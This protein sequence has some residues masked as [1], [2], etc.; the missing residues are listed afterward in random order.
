MLAVEL[1]VDCCRKTQGYEILVTLH[2][3]V[4]TSSAKAVHQA[5]V[6]RERHSPTQH[7]C[8]RPNWI[9]GAILRRFF[10][11]RFHQ[12]ELFPLDAVLLLPESIQVDYDTRKDHKGPAK[13]ASLANKQLAKNCRLAMQALD[14]TEWFSEVFHESWLNGLVIDDWHSSWIPE[15]SEWFEIVIFYP[16]VKT[17]IPD[18][19]RTLEPLAVVFQLLL[20]SQH[21]S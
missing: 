19:A 17:F 15:L 1:L 21:V 4:R 9:A 13:I 2:T 14:Q 20:I 7:N 11:A 18:Q 12:T 6:V 16:Q 10:A 8:F 3:N 5:K